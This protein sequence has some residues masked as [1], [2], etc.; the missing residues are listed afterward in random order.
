MKIP[1]GKMY[2]QVSRQIDLIINHSSLEAMEGF[3]MSA[4]GTLR[5]QN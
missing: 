5:A 2:L 3:I 1:K 4:Q